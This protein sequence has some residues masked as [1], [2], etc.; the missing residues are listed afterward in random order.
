MYSTLVRVFYIGTNYYGSQWQPELRTIQGEIIEAVNQWTCQSYLPEIVQFAGRTDRGVSSL[1]Q[2]ALIR[3][4]KPLDVNQVNK[5]LPEDITLWAHASVSDDFKPRFDTLMRHYRYYLVIDKIEL[6]IN[7][8]QTA[9]HLVI[10]SHNFSRLSKPDRNRGTITTILNSY[11]EIKK[12][13]LVYDVIG[14]NF[15]WKLIRKIVT[16][17]IQIGSGKVFIDTAIDLI[18]HQ[19]NLPGGITP[20]P[21]EGLFLIESVVTTRMTE[22]KYAL[23]RIQNHINERLRFYKQSATSLITLTDDFLFDRTCSF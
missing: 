13:I 10:G 2:I 5:Y 8:M 22:S 23:R 4:E 16:L 21:P 20:A 18:E 1:G 12:D 14:T 17:L 15:L 19:K 11:V 3:T 7:R 6:D 9:A